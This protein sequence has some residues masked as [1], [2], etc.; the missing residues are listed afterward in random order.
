M[1]ERSIVSSPACREGYEYECYSWEDEDGTP[2]SMGTWRNKELEAL[3]AKVMELAYKAAVLVYKGLDYGIP[4][5]GL[6]GHPVDI[7]FCLGR[8]LPSYM[9]CTGGYKLDEDFL[10]GWEDGMHILALLCPEIDE[11]K[12]YG[13]LW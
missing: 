6:D 4:L 8:N 7:S 13:F 10:D 1:K 9:A 11:N 5:L 12:L 2:C 3:E